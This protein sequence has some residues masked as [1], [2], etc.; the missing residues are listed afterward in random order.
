M[1]WTSAGPHRSSPLRIAKLCCFALRAVI[2][3]T[4]A[5]RYQDTPGLVPS[6][7]ASSRTQDYLDFPRG[8]VPPYGASPFLGAEPLCDSPS[9]CPDTHFEPGCWRSASQV[10]PQDSCFVDARPQ[11]LS[12]QGLHLAGQLSPALTIRP[13]DACASTILASTRAGIM[14]LLEHI[15][16]QQRLWVTVTYVMCRKEYLW[17][18]SVLQRVHTSL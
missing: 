14:S 18:V 17:D 4:L 12:L 7:V 10:L 3:F 8:I 15:V 2:P 5:F 11:R 6:Q 1:G 9:S 16:G 13:A